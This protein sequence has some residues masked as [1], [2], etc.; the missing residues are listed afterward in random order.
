M[1]ART[2]TYWI[3]NSIYRN[4]RQQRSSSVTDS[5]KLIR[6]ICA[7]SN[8]EVN[9]I[10][11]LVVISRPFGENQLEALDGNKTNETV[12]A[13][14][15]PRRLRWRRVSANGVTGEISNVASI[16]GAE[17]GEKSLRAREEMNE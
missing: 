1:E 2:R 10:T 12:D 15:L 13:C 9:K 3:T 8:T 7:F 16:I 17:W 14:F 4:R 5:R 11:N 6:D